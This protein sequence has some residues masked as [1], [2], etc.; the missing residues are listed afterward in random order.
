MAIMTDLKTYKQKK[1]KYMIHKNTLQLEFAW[2]D[3]GHV[4][5]TD[6]NRV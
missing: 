1:N 3:F 5:I 6:K 4:D 2:N